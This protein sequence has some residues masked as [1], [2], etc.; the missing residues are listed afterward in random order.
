[1]G[2]EKE[3]RGREGDERERKVKGRE[4]EGERK[5]RGGEEQGEN[6]RRRG[7]WGLPK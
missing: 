6:R 2:E 1:M 4:E 7:E 5:E 3:R